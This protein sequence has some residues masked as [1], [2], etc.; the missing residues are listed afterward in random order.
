MRW[1]AIRSTIVRDK[2]SAENTM[3]IDTQPQK[4]ELIPPKNITPATSTVLKALA[5]LAP[6]TILFI[7][8]YSGAF[9]P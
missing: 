1:G 2:L 7:A 4:S 5:I 9:R 6:P 8:L 3:K